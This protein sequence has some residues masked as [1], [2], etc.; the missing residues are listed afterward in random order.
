LFLWIFIRWIY[1]R[2]L[3]NLAHLAEEKTH[4]LSVEIEDSTGII[5]L[6]VTITAT[7]A[8]EEATSDGESSA[9]IALDIMP[10]KLTDADFKHYVRNNKKEISFIFI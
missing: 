1:F 10:S 3:C 9:N 5:E 6:F 7:T 2:A 4:R 8:L